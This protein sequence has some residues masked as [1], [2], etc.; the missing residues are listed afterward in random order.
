MDYTTLF[1]STIKSFPSQNWWCELSPLRPKRVILRA[2]WWNA[3]QMTTSK[4]HNANFNDAKLLVTVLNLSQKGH[5]C[6]QPICTR[7]ITIY[8]L[9]ESTE[10]L[11][12]GS[13]IRANC[14]V[15]PISPTQLLPTCTM[16]ALSFNAYLMRTFWQERY[17]C[18]P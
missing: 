7:A 15:L 2:F 5:I 16:R 6:L 4:M 14:C 8:Y 12:G 18:V 11:S 10:W 3:Y 17:A 9:L 13:G 1:D